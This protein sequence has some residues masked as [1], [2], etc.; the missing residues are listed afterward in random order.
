M[1]S[2]GGAYS[3]NQQRRVIGSSGYSIGGKN[4]LVTLGTSLVEGVNYSKASGVLKESK[5]SFHLR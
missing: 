2:R 4:N 3:I 5:G 1:Y